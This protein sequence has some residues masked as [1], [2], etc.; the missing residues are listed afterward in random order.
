MWVLM[1]FV[2]VPISIWYGRKNRMQRKVTTIID[3]FYKYIWI[4]FGV[5]MFCVIFLSVSYQH[6]PTPFILV[7]MAF[8][9]FI[10]G[11]TLKFKPLIY[12]SIIF[13]ISAIL[14]FYVQ[15]DAL[16]LLIFA[17]SVILGYIVPGFYLRKQQFSK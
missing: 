12:G 17:G 10:S 5:S 15:S 8:A 14:L 11:I 4:G 1:P 13:W 7:L 6:T 9:V 3:E 16:Q 2:G